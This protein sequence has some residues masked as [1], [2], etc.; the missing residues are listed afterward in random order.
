M[1][2]RIHNGRVGEQQSAMSAMLA[3]TTNQWLR[4]RRVMT[5]MRGGGLTAW[6]G[7]G[8][9]R[10]EFVYYR[11]AVERSLLTALTSCRRLFL[12]VEQLLAGDRG[13]DRILHH[14]GQRDWTM[15]L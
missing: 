11:P 14:V 5:S 12:V 9:P 8:R 7:D 10:C 1:L 15:P 4:Q 6:H 13:S 2:H 3:V